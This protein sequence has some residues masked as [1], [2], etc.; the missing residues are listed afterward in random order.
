MPRFGFRL[1]LPLLLIAAAVKPALADEEE[2][3]APLIATQPAPAQTWYG[4]QTLLADGAG[5]AGFA[6]CVNL[7]D[8]SDAEGICVVPFLLAAP[9]VH[10]AHGNP[11][12]AG[13]SFLLNG[14]LP[15]AG[16]LIGAAAADCGNGDFLCGLGEAAVGLLIGVGV[17][18]TIDAAISFDS[19]AAPP[20]AVARRAPTLLPTV[21]LTSGSAGLGLA[22]RF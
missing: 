19:E 15:I 9:A 20:R 22:G 6:G 1:A 4:W 21:S 10:I 11:G 2:P 7:L 14:G 18:A 13:I 8:N 12:R 5:I 16:A 3:V 17:A